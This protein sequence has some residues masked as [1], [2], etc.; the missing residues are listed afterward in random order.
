MRSEQEQ[1][2]HDGAASEMAVNRVV[3][4]VGITLIMFV[5][6]AERGGPRSE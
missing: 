4:R 1:L 2:L 3:S 6:R 5:S